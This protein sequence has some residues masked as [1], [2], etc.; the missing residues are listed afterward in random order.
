MTTGIRP[1]R[2]KPRLTRHL[3]MVHAHESRMAVIPPPPPSASSRRVHA[4]GA[5]SRAHRRSWTA[6]PLAR[7]A[8]LRR[9]SPSISRPTVT[10]PP[11]AKGDAAPRATPI[12]MAPPPPPPVGSGD[13]VG[14]RR[15]SS[16]ARACGRRAASST[17]A[18]AAVLAPPRD[19]DVVRRRGRADEG[20]APKGA[21]RAVR[22]SLDA[23][24]LARRC[25]G[26][27][28]QPSATKRSQNRYH[29]N[30]YHQQHYRHRRR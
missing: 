20:T 28:F 22:R 12:E 11:A 21:S 27:W 23:A 6:L 3:H 18:A 10:A 7:R 29:Q 5:G 30:R 16:P 9:C 15:L 4:V 13:A 24:A 26:P 19:A 8:R 2:R 17:I 14:G 25:P 1:S